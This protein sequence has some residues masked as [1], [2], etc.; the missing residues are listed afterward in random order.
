MLQFFHAVNDLYGVD[1][2]A[3]TD[4]DLRENKGYKVIYH[5]TVDRSVTEEQI[6]SLNIKTTEDVDKDLTQY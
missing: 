2:D 4:C 5:E 6:R 3:D 1:F